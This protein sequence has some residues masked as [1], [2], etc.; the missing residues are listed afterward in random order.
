[1]ITPSFPRALQLVGLALA[2]F[3]MVACTPQTVYVDTADDRGDVVMGL[4]YRDFESAAGEM[5][6]G[7]LG[8]GALDH[9]MGGRYVLVVSRVT[10]DTMQRI[11]TDQLV[12]KIRSDLLQSG[13]VVVTTA[14]G[15]DGPEDQMNM[16]VRELR[17]SAEFNQNTVQGS[18]QL[19]AP[20]LSLSGIIRQRNLSMDQRQQQVE[21]YFELALT[22]LSTGL[23]IWEDQSIIVK[24]GS[25]QTVA[26]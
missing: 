21:Y 8:S 4:D 19:I 14:V 6:E 12:R 10:N 16:A 1:M 9:P 20:D 11:S 5:V 17:D 7:M 2:G 24:R 13:R 3:L 23:A 22:D 18:G 25:N 15:L 26:W